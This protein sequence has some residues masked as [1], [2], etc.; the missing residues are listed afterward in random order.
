M[1]TSQHERNGL[2]E[3]RSVMGV[4]VH[5]LSFLTGGLAA[6]VVYLAAR[7]EYTKENARH[8]INWYLSVLVLAVVA[9]GT[10]FLGADDLEVGGE[11]VEWGILPEP[12]ATIVSLIGVVLVLVLMLAMIATLVF[13]MIATVKAIFGTAWKYP[14]SRSF[15]GDD[16]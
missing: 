6:I 12:I 14:L 13:W 7:H 15:I 4:L 3:E 16:T 5:P 11:P 10:F 2:L 9:F 1:S 8:V